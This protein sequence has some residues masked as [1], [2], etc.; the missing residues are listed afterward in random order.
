MARVTGRVMA[1]VRV[2]VRVRVRAKVRVKVGNPPNPSPFLQK[3][4]ADAPPPTLSVTGK[5]PKLKGSPNP[6]PS[7]GAA[8]SPLHCYPA[9]MWLK[10][11][12]LPLSMPLSVPLTVPL[13]P[14]IYT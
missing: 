4:V 11:R 9:H 3:V 2:R 6:E 14:R 12:V 13:S 10:A 5:I 8:A 7:S 1:R